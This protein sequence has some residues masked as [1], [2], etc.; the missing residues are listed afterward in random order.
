[1]CK[2]I[3]A[4][5]WIKKTKRTIYLYRDKGFSTIGVCDLNM[6]IENV[7]KVIYTRK[8]KLSVDKNTKGCLR[9]FNN[10]CL[11]TTKNFNFI[12]FFNEEEPI[13]DVMLILNKTLDKRE[14]IKCFKITVETL[15]NILKEKDF[16]IRNILIISPVKM[17][18]ITT[19]KIF[20]KLEDIAEDVFKKVL[21]KV[22]TKKIHEYLKDF[23]ISIEKLVDAG[24]ELCVGVETTEKLRNK[25]KHQIN[26]ALDDINVVTLIMAAMRVEEDFHFYR[27][28]GFNIDDDPAY[29]YTDEVFGMA[30]ANQIAGTKAIFNFKRYDEE[31]PGIISKLPPLMDDVVAG[32]I[33]GC[34]SKIFEE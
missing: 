34:M 3:D 5:P 31:K 11:E 22:K 33:A 30:I 19:D 6:D 25:L 1:M 17:Q 7:K 20:S 21:R 23:G 10:Y 16:E 12:V 9:G 28:E 2:D 27:I 8:S 18:K 29:L 26:K 32:L 14:M 24:M 4:I 15:K 13:F